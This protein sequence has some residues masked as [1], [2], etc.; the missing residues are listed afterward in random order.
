MAIDLRSY[1]SRSEGSFANAQHAERPIENC[2]V[3]INEGP[4]DPSK[5]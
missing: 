3:A 5:R 4:F 2:G 1:L